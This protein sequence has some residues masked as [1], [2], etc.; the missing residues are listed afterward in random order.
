MTVERKIVSIVGA[1]GMLLDP[2]FSVDCFKFMIHLGAQGG[3]VARSLVQNPHFE[4]RCITRD[5]D[6]LAAKK[7]MNEGLKVIQADGTKVGEME[8][9]L[10]GSWGVFINVATEVR[11]RLMI[12]A[13]ETT[14]LFVR[15]WTSRLPLRNKSLFCRVL[16]LPA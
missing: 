11:F 13:R 10:T 14:D 6:S 1:T 12:N 5:A 4:V 8:A 2:L 15:V 7:L 3:S 9:A 16:Q